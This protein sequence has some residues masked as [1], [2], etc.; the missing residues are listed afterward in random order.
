M[1]K[2]LEKEL[3]ELVKEVL[4]PENRTKLLLAVLIAKSMSPIIHAH[5]HNTLDAIH[6]RLVSYGDP[7]F[8]D[9]VKE[10]IE[11]NQAKLKNY[12]NIVNVNY[13]LLN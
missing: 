4:K 8:N 2:E 12:N 11:R 9:Y 6:G 3:Q 10:M 5:Q 7:L 13:S 1:D